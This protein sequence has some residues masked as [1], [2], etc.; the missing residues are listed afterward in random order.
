MHRSAQ[1]DRC[2]CTI[3]FDPFGIDLPLH[4]PSPLDR[5][6]RT[7]KLDEDTVSGRLYQGP[8][9]LLRLRGDHLAQNRH[10]A[11]AS[12]RLITRHQDRVADD[13]DEGDCSESPI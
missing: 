5:I 4:L 10:P 3:V 1:R 8:T 9:V 11:L 6:V 12:A 7:R 13:V 2:G